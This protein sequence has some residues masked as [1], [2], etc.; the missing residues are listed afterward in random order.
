MHPERL[1]CDAGTCVEDHY[2]EQHGDEHETA[3]CFVCETPIRED[4]TPVFAEIV[5]H[6]NVNV[7]FP[8]YV[9]PDGIPLQ[10]IGM[11]YSGVLRTRPVAYLCPRHAGLVELPIRMAWPTSF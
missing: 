8:M 9:M 4:F 1:V 10:N 5:L 7:E 3:R 2:R 11:A 6:K